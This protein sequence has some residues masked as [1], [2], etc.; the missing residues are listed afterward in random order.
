MLIRELDPKQMKQAATF[1]W[2]LFT[3]VE[4]R[5]YPLYQTEEALFREFSRRSR[6]TDSE[7]L[8]C[9]RCDQLEGIMSCFCIPKDRYVQTTAICSAP[10][11]DEVIDSFLD[12]LEDTYPRCTSY[13]GIEKR[14]LKLKMALESHGYSLIEDSADMR[15]SIADFQGET[16]RSSIVHIDRTLLPDY[17]QYHEKHFSDGYWNA[18][19]IAEDFDRWDIFA[20]YENEK[21]IGGLYLNCNEKL[22]LAEIFGLASVNQEVTSD[23]LNRAVSYIQASRPSMKTVMFMI[24]DDTAYEAALKAGFKVESLYCCWR[25]AL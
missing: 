18:E 11:C 7:L 14:N 15:M 10:G 3:L 19:R 4:N 22:A 9:T 23:L 1:A 12:Y 17:L 25:K 21:I 6:E 8:A 5:S 2:K 24:E 20:A 13:V 16:Q